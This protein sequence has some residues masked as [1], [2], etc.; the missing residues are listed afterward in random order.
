MSPPPVVRVGL[1]GAGFAA[2]LH[3]RA[4]R[5]CGNPAAQVVAIAI[6]IYAFFHPLPE[7]ERL[8]TAAVLVL[9]VVQIIMTRPRAAGAPGAG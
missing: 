1:I 6:Q 8:L 5:A 3:L 2:G 7:S 9:A 4:Y